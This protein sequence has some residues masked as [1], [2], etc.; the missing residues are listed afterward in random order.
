M[1]KVHATGQSKIR[2]V[3]CVGTEGVVEDCLE[4]GIFIGVGCKMAGGWM[5]RTMTTRMR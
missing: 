2:R 1:D 3:E 5:L 4:Q